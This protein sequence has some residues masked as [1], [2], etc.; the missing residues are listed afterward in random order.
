MY[1]LIAIVIWA[2]FFT[3]VGR[4]VGYLRDKHASS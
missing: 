2:V 3:V 1:S 4:I